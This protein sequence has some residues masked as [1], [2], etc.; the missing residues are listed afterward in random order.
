MASKRRFVILVV[1]GL[2]VVAVGGIAC[3][4][5]LTSTSH[6]VRQLERDLARAD[7]AKRQKILWNLGTL[8]GPRASAI[9]SRTLQESDN[10]HLREAAAYGLQK[11]QARERLE[12]LRA[13]AVKESPAEVQAKMAS[14]VARL[15]GDDVQPWLRQVS[16]APLS[17]LGLGATIGRLELGDLSA[18]GILF[19]YLKGP[20]K[21]MRAFAAE[22]TARWMTFIGEAIGRP[23]DMTDA[24]EREVTDADADRMIR[25][26]RQNVTPR[27]LVDNVIWRK[28]ADPKWRRVARLMG[29]RSKAIDFLDIE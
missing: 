2:T 19:R 27:L 24:P 22:R 21:A 15:G 4:L 10:P 23:P 6:Q 5:W 16:D 13:A 20:D 3:A 26:W 7:Q 17:W 9:L 11:M 28:G 25:W 29:A 12:L 1:T 18:D 8:G 14:Y